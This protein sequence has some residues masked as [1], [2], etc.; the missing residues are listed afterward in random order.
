M[1]FFWGLAACAR[2]RRTAA[3]M[4]LLSWS[5]F[6]WAASPGADG[7]DR[8][9]QTAVQDAYALNISL[10][11]AIQSIASLGGYD[12]SAVPPGGSSSAP[13]GVSL[14]GQAS[15]I[16]QAAALWPL[17]SLDAALNVSAT[18]LSMRY[19]ADHDVF[20]DMSYWDR[21]DSSLRMVYGS[22]SPA[23]SLQGKASEQVGVDLELAVAGGV[24]HA[25]TERR[26]DADASADTAR[27]SSV[28]YGYAG[29][30]GAIAYGADYV[31]TG[32]AYK[33]FLRL[34]GS[35]LRPD[36]EAE[37]VWL[38]LPVS[39]RVS[40]RASTEQLRKGLGDATQK[41][42]YIDELAGLKADFVF[43]QWPY[44]GS[45][46]WY[47]EGRRSADAL[48]PTDVE[49]G[50]VRS[51]GATLELRNAWGNHSF[52]ASRA[53]SYGGFGETVSQSLNSTLYPAAGLSF[54][55]DAASDEDSTRTAVGLW[56][57]TYTSDT[58]WA[59]FAP[60]AKRF[61]LTWTR[62]S[63]GYSTL[64]RSV[65]YSETYESVTVRLES[66]H[67]LRRRL[68]LALTLQTSAYTDRVYSSQSA[69]DVALWLQLG[70]PNLVRPRARRLYS[71]RSGVLFGP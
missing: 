48:A 43:Q 68:P 58:L 49:G 54:G 1:G 50:G 45:S 52:S 34:G 28:Q 57:G 71:A 9:A 63:D 14:A 33:D 11:S 29:S 5:G 42:G 25:H 69:D 12:V 61:T 41:P 3:L 46:L 26:L 19:G 18:A 51:E 24:L 20:V 27:L 6:S 56:L 39:D 70:R 15:P 65:D 40:L 31:R 32:S 44:V 38:S 2:R 67:V 60:S 55:L 4:T 53:S 21:G 66:I 59:S 7:V 37:S 22:R 30:L 13:A 8:V 35:A 16:G 23:N 47:R 36:R 17:A 62:Y 64:D 10:A